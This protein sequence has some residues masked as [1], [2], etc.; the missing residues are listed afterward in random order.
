MFILHS[1]IKLKVQLSVIPSPRQYFVQK[2]SDWCF[3]GLVW[4]QFAVN[5]FKK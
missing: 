1:N 2:T 3:C 5:F 4:Y